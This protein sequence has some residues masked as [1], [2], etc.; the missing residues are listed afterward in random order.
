MFG[1]PAL[2]AP[3]LSRPQELEGILAAI[4]KS[5]ALIEFTPDGTIITA[6]GNFLQAMG[7]ALEEIQGHHH[8]MF[9]DPAEAGSAAYHEFWAALKRG[10]YQAA[11]YKRIGKDGREVW[12]QAS[13]N[14]ILDQ[15][16]RPAKI[17]KFATDVTDAKLRAT[18][19]RGQ[20]DAIHRSQAIIEFDLDGTIVTAN[21]NFL[22]ALGYTLEE[23]RGKH[24]RMFVDPVEADG[25]AYREFWAGLNRG[26]YQAA[27]Y[28]RIG[29]GGR[30][31]WIQA[32]YNPILDL[33]GRPCRVVKFATDVTRQVIG[34][35]DCAQLC[36]AISEGTRGLTQAITEIS[37]SMERSRDAT[38]SAFAQI[39][40]ADRAMKSLVTAAEAMVGVTDLIKSISS[41][42]NLLSL[43]AAIEA[44]SAGAAGRG[45]SVVAGEVKILAGQCKGAAEGIGKE[46]DG[47][48]RASAEVAAALSAVHGSVESVC[49]Y[50]A[51]TA[52]AV[53]EQAAATVEIS[54]NME[55]VDRKM[56]GL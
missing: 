46:I 12:I 38:Q 20:I 32:S 24:H 31:V 19:C 56:Q 15:S 33:N 53:E 51:T 1:R 14:P 23:I 8:R 27:E 48:R 35:R 41:Q 55:Q 22:G 28:K 36:E 6:N 52:A 29:K 5:Q 47:L 26:E 37:E 44:A 13:Y 21:D 2:A 7:Y 50:V 45:F 25:A 16:G 42:I 34:K 18:H 17:I 9:V 54:T 10:E 30:A 40:T 39:G 4:D 3:R 11:E 43:N 49:Q